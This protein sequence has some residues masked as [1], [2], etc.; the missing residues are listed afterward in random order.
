MSDIP[1]MFQHCCDVYGKMLEH[2]TRD[3]ETGHQLYEGALTKLVTGEMGLSMPY[4]S[5]TTRFL[6]EMDCIRQLRRGGGGTPSRWLLI[7][8]PTEELFRFAMSKINVQGG[9]NEGAQA[10]RDMNV[11]L[12]ELEQRIDVVEATLEAG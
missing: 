6:R 2:A 4:Y 8:T 10:L 12:S 7:Q 5:T 3:P 11:R 9:S 1:A